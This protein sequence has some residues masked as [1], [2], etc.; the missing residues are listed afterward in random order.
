MAEKNEKKKT[1]APRVEVTLKKPHRH[2]GKDHEA[3]DKIKVTE[4]QRNWLKEREVI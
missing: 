3:G 1:P 4:W 2:A